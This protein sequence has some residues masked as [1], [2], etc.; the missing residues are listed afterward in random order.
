M[1]Q[2]DPLNCSARVSRAPLLSWVLPHGQT[3]VAERTATPLSM[4]PSDPTVGTLVMAHL[5]PVQCRDVGHV[6]V[7]VV[8]VVA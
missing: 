4:L 5:V 8:D 7:G 2:V 1:V 3:S 6:V